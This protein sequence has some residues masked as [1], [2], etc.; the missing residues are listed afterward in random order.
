[1]IDLCL[2]GMTML[3]TGGPVWSAEWCPLPVGLVSPQYIAISCVQS[4]ESMNLLDNPVNSPGLIQIWNCGHLQNAGSV[5]DFV[6]IINGFEAY[7]CDLNVL[8]TTFL[9]EQLK[10]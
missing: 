9:G 4:V 2:G 6:H 10:N 5:M 1:M 3:H 7:L 8:G